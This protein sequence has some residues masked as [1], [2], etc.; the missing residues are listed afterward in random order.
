MSSTPGFLKLVG[1]RAKPSML[2]HM[3]RIRM[4][5][6]LEQVVG[7]E[8]YGESVFK[9]ITWAESEGRVEELVRA[10]YDEAGNSWQI[11][12]NPLRSE[13]RWYTL[14]DVMASTLLTG[15][16]PRVL[17]AIGLEPVGGSSTGVRP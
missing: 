1:G 11:G 15:R 10:R 3:L 8:D 4:E 12:V 2:E 13:P 9:L 7:G 17:R 14:A 5:I 16:P 6:Q